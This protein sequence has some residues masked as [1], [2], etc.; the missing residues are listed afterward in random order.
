MTTCINESARSGSHAQNDCESAKAAQGNDAEE[1]VEGQEEISKIIA[2]TER[3][4]DSESEA[5]DLTI[6]T[7]EMVRAGV[8]A[9]FACPYDMPE[10]WIKR[11][12]TVMRA[13]ETGSWKN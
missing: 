7:D 13:V 5:D 1:T 10:D 6:V 8:H 3:D 12:Y 11:I 9:Y 4:Y 2:A